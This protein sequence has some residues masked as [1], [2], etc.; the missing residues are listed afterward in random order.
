MESVKSRLSKRDSLLLPGIDWLA[1]SLRLRQRGDR[2]G[3][4][5]C[6]RL[7]RVMRLNNRGAH[8]RRLP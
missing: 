7:A 6:L 1:T 5:E 3:Y 4:R 8:R 2:L